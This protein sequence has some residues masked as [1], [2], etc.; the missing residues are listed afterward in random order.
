MTGNWAV[1][2]PITAG[3]TEWGKV[4]VTWWTD[5]IK[6]LHKNDFIMA[7]KTDPQEVREGIAVVIPSDEIG[8]TAAENR[9]R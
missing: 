6:N 4:A 8:R 2:T 7:A 9:T 1:R 3:S 5:K